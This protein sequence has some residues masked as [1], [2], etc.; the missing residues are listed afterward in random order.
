[1]SHLSRI[2]TIYEII[3]KSIVEY[4]DEDEIQL[5]EG[6]PI[7][8]D[9][10]E[11]T[12]NNLNE[13]EI[14]LQGKPFSLDETGCNIERQLDICII[15]NTDYVRDITLRLTKYSEDMMRLIKD[16]VLNQGIDLTFVQGSEIGYTKNNKE[17]S[18]SYKGSKTL[19]SSMI[20][21]S[22]LLRYDI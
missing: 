22:Y 18:E 3:G 16:L 10:S 1:M 20:I 12:P 2:A 14:I 21:L 13:T 4:V 5:F 15:H 6:I 9:M 19:F 17:D 8:W 11:V 7:R